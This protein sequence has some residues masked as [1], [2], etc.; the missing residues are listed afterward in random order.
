VGNP[1]A[2]QRPFTSLYTHGLAR[3]AA[4]VPLLR[5]AEPAF[6]VERTIGLARRAAEAHAA[7]VAFPELGISAYA[8]DDLFHQEALTDAVVAAL[9]ELVE[10]SRELAPVIVVGA[11]LRAEGGVFN[12][13]V[14]VQRGRVLGVVPKSYL[15]D[16]REY[17]EERQ[18]RAA[19]E[20]MG[21]TVELLGAEVPFGPNV[22]FAARDLPG[23]VAHVEICEDLWTPIPPSTYGALAGATVLVNLSAS[24][25]TVGK[26]DYR[27]VLCEAHSARLMGAYVYTAAG[28]GESTTDL[29]W[30]GQALICENGDLLVEAQRFAKEEQLICADIDLGRIAADRATT[31]SYGDSIHD[32]LADIA[33]FRRVEF[34]L[35]ISEPRVPLRRR[36]ERFPYV[37]ADAA[38]RNE[39]CEEVYNIQVRGLETRL[40]A[41]GI[42]KV[43]IGVS[44]GLDS[45]H[46][47]IVV[48]RAMDRLG[49]PRSNV[50][51]YTLPGF[52]TGSHTKGNAWKLMEA[53]GVSAREI[54]IKPSARQMLED[55]D[56]PAARGEKDYDITYENVQAGE[57]TSHLFRLANFHNGIVIGTGDLSELALGWATYGVGDHMSHY[58]VNA[59]VP[60]TLVRFIIRWAIDTEQFEPDASAVLQS[61]LDTQIS[62]ELIPAESDEPTADSESKVG[63]YEL[64]DFFLFHV[65]RFGYKPS[66]VAFLAQ[67]AWGDRDRGPWPDLIPPE[68]RN[69]YSLAEIKHWLEVFLDRFFRLSQ[70]KRSAIPNA[71]KVGSGGSLSPRG[72]WR[73]PS[74]ASAKVWLEE[75]RANV[76]D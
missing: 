52:A 35:G 6:N 16:Y 49:L 73:A 8:I 62:P 45:T 5:P 25:I 21:D 37:P 66:K 27:R 68:A 48:A 9:G 51:A 53:L 7:L 74:D 34:E 4:A 12:C 30:D 76:P 31:S 50:L 10:A 24:N 11:P 22:L 46:A 67:H 39:R 15:P 69:E 55:I 14:V 2:M 36:L 54:D 61:V 71:P 32:H 58:S 75:L 18:F 60:K 17:Y 70:F 23:F 26:A 47:L 59:S 44:G 56:H 64:Q 43:V 19:R 1:D 57:R 38:T 72:D 13:G 28:E 20:A 3:V 63:P 29:A 33:G 40:K 41:T 42:E 65:L